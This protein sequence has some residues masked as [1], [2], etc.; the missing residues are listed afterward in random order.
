MGQHLP[1]RAALPRLRAPRRMESLLARERV[2]AAAHVGPFSLYPIRP[3]SHNRPER[4]G[5]DICAW[6]SHWPFAFA[7]PNEAA[8]DGRL[9]TLGE[10]AN[11]ALAVREALCT[12]LC[13]SLRQSARGR[14]S[15]YATSE[16]HW[17]ASGQAPRGDG[18][19]PAPPRLAKG[20]ATAPQHLGGGLD[21]P[22][23][24]AV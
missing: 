10:A 4:R 18:R 9:S 21:K 19:R 12:N 15:A 17:R 7:G 2:P 24:K 14:S 8:L 1:A 13:A 11:V 6:R 22:A 23:A 5:G 3:L 20:G 16:D